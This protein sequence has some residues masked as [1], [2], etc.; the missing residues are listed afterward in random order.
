M[1]GSIV[2]AL[3]AKAV[4]T[5]LHIAG[6]LADMG[7]KKVDPPAQARTQPVQAPP[8]QVR[9]Q[10]VQAPPVVAVVDPKKVAEANEQQEVANQKK[11]E[12]K[13][14]QDKAAAAVKEASDAKKEE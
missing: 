9:T 2:L 6:I 7:V 10:P 14:I 11:E 12:A 8:P 13:E 4:P 3:S 1:I 5:G